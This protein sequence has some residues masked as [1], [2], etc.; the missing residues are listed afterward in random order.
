MLSPFL[1]RS[2]ISASNPVELSLSFMSNFRRLQSSRSLKNDKSGMPFI[3][4]AKDP[5]GLLYSGIWTSFWL[6]R[7]RTTTLN[8]VIRLCLRVNNLFHGDAIKNPQYARI[9][10]IYNNSEVRDYS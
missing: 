3:F 7:E 2:E 1:V 10:K 4:S 5:S 6:L 9:W 8:L